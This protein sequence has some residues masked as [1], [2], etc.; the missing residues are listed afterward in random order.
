M[1]RLITSGLVFLAASVA[2]ATALAWGMNAMGLGVTIAAILL[3]IAAAVGSY[4][5]T[6]SLKADSSPPPNA[7][8][9]GV[10]LIFAFATWRSFFWLL[11]TN[12]DAWFIL[13]RYNLGDIALH[14]NLIQYLARATPFWPQ[15]SILADTALTYPIGMDLFNALLLNLR[16]DLVTGLLWT[17]LLGSV[18]TAYALWKWGRAFTVAAFLFGGGLVE[19]LSLFSST[20][21]QP[22]WKNPFLALFVTQR[23]WL[24]ALP[25]TLLLLWSWRER[26][27]KTTP[28][29]S[30]VELLL[31]AVMPLF[32]IHAFL[33]LSATLLFLWLLNPAHRRRFFLFTAAAFLPAT[34]CAALVTNGFQQTGGIHWAIGWL[35]G[36]QPLTFWILNFGI[37]LPL[38][39]VL[40]LFVY[41]KHDPIAE[42]FVGTG[43]VVFLLCTLVSF[44]PWPWDNT[45][46]MLLS[47]LA[48]TPF[49][50]D[51]VLKPIAVPVR[52]V[53][54]FLLF[55]SGAIT[56]WTGLNGTNG[57]SLIKRAEVDR[58]RTAIRDIPAN[59]RFACA[60]EYN[61][62]VLFLGRPVIA[63]Y[64]GHL[65]SHGLDYKPTLQKL[66]T[67]MQ[68][69]AGWESALQSLRVRYLF[70]GPKEMDRYPKSTRPWEACGVKIAQ[71]EWGAVWDLQNCL[72]KTPEVKPD[73]NS[74]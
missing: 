63:G 64:E 17:G 8:E 31:Y 62:P 46:L 16:I 47:W 27:R 49:L 45:K 66:T 29:P 9:I 39:I 54:C 10:L 30:W 32:N 42:T 11:Y 67:L 50:W 18:M 35:Q 56:L 44:A 52:V 1:T 74:Q 15:S 26:L 38:L 6:K 43:S 3:G 68:G 72:E 61:H 55:G 51:Y 65:W 40:C 53:L 4:I 36:A 21:I 41:R 25:A 73:Q 7:L 71:T 22:E 48:A 19:L 13:S 69:D 34:A 14:A 59:E 12:G 28:L 20:L 2:A 5:A 58:V 57:F 24:Y 60:P 37:S 70:W 23:G 33:F